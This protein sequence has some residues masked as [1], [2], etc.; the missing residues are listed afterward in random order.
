MT[1]AA[2]NCAHG[3]GISFNVSAEVPPG[4]IIVV[5]V[6]PAG[7]VVVVLAGIVV[8]PVGTVV[9]VLAGV[10]VVPVGIV[11]VVGNTDVVVVVAHG[12][13][14]PLAW[15][16][17]HVVFTSACKGASIKAQSPVFPAG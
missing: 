4:I 5:V 8:V 14:G 7:V 3:S 17:R 16:V 12:V 15:Q 9:V 13:G 1:A 6:V 2:P 11:V 10:V